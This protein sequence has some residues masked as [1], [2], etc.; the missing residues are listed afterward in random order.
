MIPWMQRVQPQTVWRKIS[1]PLLR[2]L[3]LVSLLVVLTGCGHFGGPP[4]SAVEAALTQRL[5]ETQ[6]AIQQQLSADAAPAPFQI[7]RVKVEHTQR[8]NLSGQTAYRVSG[9]YTLKGQYL[10]RNLRQSSNPFEIYLRPGPE[11][12]SWQGFQPTS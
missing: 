9:T 8:V 3:A 12:D 2:G 1:Q 7:T 5:M 11:E 4:D 10:S 6:Q